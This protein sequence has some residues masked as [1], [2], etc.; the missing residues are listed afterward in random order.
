MADPTEFAARV[1]V[2]IP[3][4]R[5]ADRVVDVIARVPPEIVAIICVDDA[6]PD[7]SGDCIERDC[8]DSRVSVVRHQTNQG[9]GGAMVSG[10]RAALVAGAD[11]VVKLDGDGQMDPT[12]IFRL[13]RP[14]VSGQADYAKGNRFF[15]PED[16][17]AMPRVRLFGN[18]AL[19][20]L[21]KLSTGYWRVFDPNNG[22]TAIHAK[23]LRLIPLDKIHK[24]YF[25]E[26][27]MLFRLNTVRAAVID[28]PMRAIYGNERSSL[29]I[30]N[31][32]PVF[33]AGHLRNFVKRIIY[34]YFLR[35]F[36]VASLEWLLGPALMTFG[37]VFGVY[38][39]IASAA[40]GVSAT[41]GTVM[42]AGLPFIVGLQLLLSAIN[43]DIENSPTRAVHP[44]L[45]D[46]TPSST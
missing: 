45:D 29:T 14:I 12:L 39:W 42:L 30:A 46:E 28:V 20:F 3:C 22:F 2:V 13:V 44:L 41:A 36:H 34:N 11:V 37:L 40:A 18:A 4:Y 23:I 9:V 15:R 27:D 32:L 6:C 24:G 43:F 17:S 19:S 16:V 8:G 1:A 38:Q 5:V 35:D 7:H 25:F 31:A 26:S 21:S 33:S 10:Y